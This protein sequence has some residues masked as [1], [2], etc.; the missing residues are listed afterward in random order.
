MTDQPAGAP[1]PA[2]P[3]FASELVHDYAQKGLTALWALA[4]GY[5]FVTPDAHAQFMSLGFG[6]ASFAASC[7]WTY[8]AAQARRSRYFAFLFAAPP[9]KS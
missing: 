4:L 2:L 5:G 8:V 9:A 1:A 7:A 3:P 6:L